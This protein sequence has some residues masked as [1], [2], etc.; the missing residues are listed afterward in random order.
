MIRGGMHEGVREGKVHS[1][2]LS[3]ILDTMRLFRAGSDQ[4]AQQ[5]THPTDTRAP[6]MN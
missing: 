4:Q 5:S 2:S 6:M 3:L 1:G